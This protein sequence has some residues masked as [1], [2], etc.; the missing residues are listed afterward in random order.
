MF[1]EL[2]GTPINGSSYRV[3]PLV[4]EQS[5]TKPSTSNRHQILPTSP[6]IEE[7]AQIV[8]IAPTTAWEHLARAEQKI[9]AEIGSSFDIHH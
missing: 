3:R 7:I 8:E 6:S 9:M 4:R 2:T 1:P 5:I